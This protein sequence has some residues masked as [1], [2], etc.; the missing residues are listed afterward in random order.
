MNEQAG[1]L[2]QSLEEGQPC[3]VCGSRHHPE[4]AQASEAAPSEG[5]LNAAREAAQAAQQVMDQAQKDCEAMKQA[6]RQRL[7][8][9]AHL[10]VEMVVSR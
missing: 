7:D 4:P 2:A 5:E 10:I 8:Q 3:P 6:A 1:I 9:A